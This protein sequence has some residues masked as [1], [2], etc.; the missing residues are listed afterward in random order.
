[1]QASTRTSSQTQPTRA[2]TARLSSTIRRSK[3][4]T[5]EE[6]SPTLT[7]SV[8]TQ[9]ASRR[10][11]TSNVYS[12]SSNSNIIYFILLNSYHGQ[13]IKMTDCRRNF[14]DL[15]LLHEASKHQICFPVQVIETI[16]LFLFWNLFLANI[17]MQIKSYLNFQIRTNP[18]WQM[19]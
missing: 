11:R 4:P 2:V 3:W 6:I 19:V 18:I 5:V 14:T 17:R 7:L 12:R 10:F 15:T 1:M 8:N 13:S 9:N 16:I